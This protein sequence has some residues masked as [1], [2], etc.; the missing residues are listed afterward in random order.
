MLGAGF[1][2]D[3]VDKMKKLPSRQSKFKSGSKFMRECQPKNTHRQ[4]GRELKVKEISENE[5]KEV[6]NRIRLEEQKERRKQR[7]LIP[8]YALISILIFIVTL[9]VIKQFLKWYFPFD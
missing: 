2:Q 7:I 4:N 8:L 5:V 1:M 9:L 6:I 3:T